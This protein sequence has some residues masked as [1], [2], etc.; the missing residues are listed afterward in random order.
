M[1]LDHF[2]HDDQASGETPGREPYRVRVL[3][4][5]DERLIADTLCCIL[6]QDGFDVTIAYSAREAI[7]RASQW[8]P[9]VFLGDVVMPGL[10]GVE[11]AIQIRRMYPACRILLLS[12]QAATVDLLGEARNQGHTFEVL[13]KPIHPTRLIALLRSPFRL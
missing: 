9:D 10:N 2:S 11:A 13:Q 12:G 1:H 5:D 6:K 4:L 7:E 3:V 8:P